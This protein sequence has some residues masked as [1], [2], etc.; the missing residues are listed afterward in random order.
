[1]ADTQQ[2]S[3]KFKPVVREMTAAERYAY[4]SLP[5]ALRNRKENIDETVVRIIDFLELLKEFGVELEALGNATYSPEGSSTFDPD[6]VLDRERLLGRQFAGELEALQTFDQIQHQNIRHES[7]LLGKDFVKKVTALQQLMESF[8]N[9]FNNTMMP[10]TRSK[11]PE[12][13]KF[14]TELRQR[15]NDISYLTRQ[16]AELTAA[17]QDAKAGDLEESNDEVIAQYHRDIMSYVNEYDELRDQY[18][19][20]SRFAFMKRRA[21]WD[22]LVARADAIKSINKRYEHYDFIDFIT[23]EIADDD[24]VED[25]QPV[26]FDTDVEVDTDATAGIEPVADESIEVE[27]ETVDTTQI[28]DVEFEDQDEEH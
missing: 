23:F 27:T 21:V 20:L 17:A 22:K 11:A 12:L 2:K 18:T 19:K 5:E 28:P 4:K 8:W 1:M 25:E 13:S 7:S 6:H 26:V 24:Y 3:G 9:R 15:V 14:E 10:F 16:H